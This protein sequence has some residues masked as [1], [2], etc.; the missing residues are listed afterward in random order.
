[1][2]TLESLVAGNFNF[3][4][5]YYYILYQVCQVVFSHLLEFLSYL[6]IWIEPM[7]I[8]K[9]YLDSKGET[10]IY[11]VL[12][13]IYKDNVFRVNRDYTERSDDSRTFN[14]L[15]APGTYIIVVQRRP[16]L[17]TYTQELDKYGNMIKFVNMWAVSTN[18]DFFSQ[19]VKACKKK[20]KQQ[21]HL[22][23]RSYDGHIYTH[24]NNIYGIWYQIG[25]VPKRSLDDTILDDSTLNTLVKTLDTFYNKP[26]YYKKY[27]I[28]YKLCILISS[29]PGMGKTS[30]IKSL[31]DKYGLNLYSMSLNSTNDKMLPYVF[32]SVKERS[33]L[34]FEDVDCMTIDRNNKNKNKKNKE[35][36]N[37]D[38]N[39]DEDEN[40]NTGVTLSGFLN[41]L[42]GIVVKEGLVVIMTTNY[43]E[44]LD[45]ALV[46]QER[47]HLHCRLEKSMEVYVKMIK[48]FFPN[49]TEEQLDKFSNKCFNEKMSLA[50][51]QAHCLKHLDNLEDSFILS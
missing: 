30:V 34:A 38:D 9:F 5:V 40:N 25:P 1:M 19:L 49:I 14:N 35:E 46:R 15:M 23:I 48:R 20:S 11:D 6:K 47:V 12:E 41:A 33:I 27:N 22:Y 4:I 26:E 32:Q 2:L 18:K 39:D 37:K 29:P 31:A 8:Q 51:L 28:P 42:D 24:K 36:I 21:K 50:D 45:A 13:Y 10:Q 7:I 44:K 3:N 43:P 17:M 16:I